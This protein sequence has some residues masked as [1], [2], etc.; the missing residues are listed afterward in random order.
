MTV[1]QTDDNQTLWAGDLNAMANAL[2]P[3]AIENGCS[4]SKGTG[5]WDSDVTAGDIVIGGE[6]V[7]ISSGTVTHTAPANDADM[8]A[9]ESRIDLVTADA[10]DTLAITEGT[11]ASNPTTPDI[12]SGEVV[13]GFWH[14]EEGDATLADADLF[15]SPALYDLGSHRSLASVWSEGLAP[16]LG[17]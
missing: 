1:N 16:G 17:G 7:A 2:L 5:D 10:T 12:P 11:A 9:G 4:V 8:D 6:D 3:E 15:D 14:I 13:L